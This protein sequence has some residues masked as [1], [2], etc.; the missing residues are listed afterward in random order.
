[1][2]QHSADE[3][4]RFGGMAMGGHRHACAFFNSAE[5]EDALLLPFLKEGLDRGER[6]FCIVDPKGRDDYRTRLGA[7]GIPAGTLEND[8]QLE[9][10][11]SVRTP[12]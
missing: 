9:L 6:G 10:R 3:P 11:D 4:I 1:M 7:V 5:E 8:G 2:E 12:C